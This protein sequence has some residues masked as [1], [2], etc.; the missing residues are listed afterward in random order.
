MVKFFCLKE[1]STCINTVI[2]ILCCVLIQLSIN[3]IRNVLLYYKYYY[4][5]NTFFFLQFDRILFFEN[6]IDMKRK[7][8]INPTLCSAVVLFCMA[9][10]CSSVLASPS[11]I[12]NI[13]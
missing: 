10:T 13:Y 4:E 7:Y 9:V 3:Q 12:Y 2:K 11:L 1:M 5:V 8:Y 6:L